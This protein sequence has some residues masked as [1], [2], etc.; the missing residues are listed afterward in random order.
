[1]NR[2][3]KNEINIVN[4][5]N[6]K[7]FMELSSFQKSVINTL[8]ENVDEKSI[9]KAS[10]CDRIAKPDIYIN[11]D[12]KIKYISIKSGVTDSIHFEDVKK[13]ILFFRSLGVSEKTQKILLFYHYGD[14][15]LNGTGT[16]RMLYDELYIKYKNLITFATNELS[17]PEIVY[18]CL[19]RFVSNGTGSRNYQVDY[20]YYGDEHYGVLCSKKDLYD[21]VLS[22]NYDHYR[23]MH[24][25]PLTFQPYLRDV[26]N[27]SV[28]KY[29]RE[30]VQ[31]KWH[32]FLTDLQKALARKERFNKNRFDKKRKRFFY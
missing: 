2:G 26:N 23:T 24:V 7:K 20:F 1:M 12:G 15:T 19:E 5:Y 22:R 8:F 14:G 9:I 18:A 16:R 11:V 29:K 21:F 4:S 17:K 27:I 30:M 13:F 32:Y 3:I 31:V 25:G 28:N 6:G 10:L